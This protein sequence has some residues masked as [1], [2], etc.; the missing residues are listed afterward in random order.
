MIAKITILQVPGEFRRPV[1]MNAYDKQA[2]GKPQQLWR[3]GGG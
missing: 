2:V 1:A 3:W